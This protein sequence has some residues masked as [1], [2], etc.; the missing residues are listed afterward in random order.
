MSGRFRAQQNISAEP[1][2]F[3]TLQVSVQIGQTGTE[4]ELTLAKT[5]HHLTPNLRI[6]RHK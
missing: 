1:A 3:K 5:P 6:Y 2:I 4:L